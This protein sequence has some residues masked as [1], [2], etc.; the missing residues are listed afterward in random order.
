MTPGA[1][2]RL[3]GRVLDSGC[4]RLGGR[5]W[6]VEARAPE[7][8]ETEILD[9]ERFVDMAIIDVCPCVHLL[10]LARGCVE[11]ILCFITPPL[12]GSGRR[13][14]SKLRRATARAGPGMC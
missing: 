2:L 4:C 3:R 13:A 14:A 9:A 1:V 5:R 7:A 8:G 10:A 11:I 6:R 12:P